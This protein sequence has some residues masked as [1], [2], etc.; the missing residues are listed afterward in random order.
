M[1]PPWIDIDWLHCGQTVGYRR[2]E[3]DSIGPSQPWLPLDVERSDS[4]NGHA[5][6][7]Q[8]KGRL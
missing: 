3:P 8:A 7:G 5:Y 2:M 6:I 4:V 1:T